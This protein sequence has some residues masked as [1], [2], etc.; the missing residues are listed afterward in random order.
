MKVIC[1]LSV[2]S[3]PMRPRLWSPKAPFADGA[4]GA[5]YDP[6]NPFSLCQDVGGTV[7][8]SSDGDPVALIQDLS[9]N[10]NHAVQDVAPA[11]PTWRTDGT[12]S[13]LEF[14]GVDDQVIINSVP[15]SLGMFGLCI[16]LEYMQYVST[17]KF[18]CWRAL[19]ADGPY[20]GISHPTNTGPINSTGNVVSHLD[21]IPAP[22]SREL[23]FAQTQSKRIATATGIPTTA[24][25]GNSWQF[26]GYSSP[27]SPPAKV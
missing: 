25:A 5:W 11:R 6:S 8:V 13:W 21:G 12:L 16:A 1:D 2:T 7:P 22:N 17:V 23:S 4:Q 19:T 27:G 24:F 9:G 14:D 10:G 18:R 3:A 20:I 26:S 15:Y